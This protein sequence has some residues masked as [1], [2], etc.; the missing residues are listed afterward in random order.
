MKKSNTKLIALI[1]VFALLITGVSSVFAI[2]RMS[3]AYNLEN[4]NSKSIYGFYREKR[5]SLDGIYL[6]SSAANRFWIPPRAFENEGICIYNLGTTCQPFVVTRNLIKEALSSQPNMDVII[7]E[8]RCLTRNPQAIEKER[9]TQISDVM[10]Y[11]SNRKEMIDNY[12]D[13]CDGIDADVDLGPMDY[14]LPL[15]RGKRK[16]LIGYDLSILDR[17]YGDSG[18]I[19]FKGYFENYDIAPQDP[20]EIVLEQK[21]IDSTLEG[22][23]DET[24]EYCKTLDQEVIFVSGPL[25]SVKGHEPEINYVLNKC[26]E[27]GFNTLDFNSQ[28]LRDELNIDWGSH[29]Y[30][31]KHLNTFGAAHFTDYMSKYLAE[32]YDLEDHRGDESYSSWQS[33]ADKLEDRMAEHRNTY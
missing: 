16:W 21:Q 3:L 24:L 29:F 2:D 20:P 4:S 19:L 13:Y 7:V 12:I 31:N 22:I 28:P 30:N 11:S 8:V 26:R 32:E 18:K 10:R 1:I 9:F 33:S 15:L 17:L 14:Y 23:L 6:G 25:K 5:D 27:A